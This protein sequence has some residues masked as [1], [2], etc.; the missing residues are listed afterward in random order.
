LL[1][2]MDI[3]IHCRRRHVEPGREHAVVR[4]HLARN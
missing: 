4:R 1:T 2:D 3:A